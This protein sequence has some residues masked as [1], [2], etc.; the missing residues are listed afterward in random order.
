M[1]FCGKFFDLT[2][3]TGGGTNLARA[4]PAVAR[5]DKCRGR[6]RFTAENDGMLCNMRT[7]VCGRLFTYH[8]CETEY[9]HLK[10]NIAIASESKYVVQFRWRLRAEGAKPGSNNRWKS[11]LGHVGRYVCMYVAGYG[12]WN[13]LANQG[14]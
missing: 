13:Y 10:Y 1:P 7:S 3:Q 11:Y 12:I 9:N 8:A 2:I 4:A 14:T 5:A 6:T